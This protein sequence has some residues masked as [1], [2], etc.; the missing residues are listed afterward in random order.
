[1]N[2]IDAWVTM[3][4]NEV[5]KFTDKQIKLAKEIK[6]RLKA[7]RKSGCTILAKQTGLYAYKDE[8]MKHAHPLHKVIDH[9][10]AYPIPYIDCGFID[11]AGADD[12]EYFEPGYIK[13]DK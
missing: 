7:L 13:Y 6:S 11:D 10:Q 4:Y 5:G 8:D 3:E 9:T 12:T 2:Y 1:M